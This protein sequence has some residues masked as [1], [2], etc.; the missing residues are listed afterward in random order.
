MS[1]PPALSSAIFFHPWPV[2][3]RLQQSNF[4]KLVGRQC[5]CINPRPSAPI[6]LQPSRRLGCGS[7][8]FLLQ[9]ARSPLPALTCHLVRLLPHSGFLPHPKRFESFLD[10]SRIAEQGLIRSVFAGTIVPRTCTVVYKVGGLHH[11]GIIHPRRRRCHGMNTPRPVFRPGFLS[12]LLSAF[13]RGP[14][15]FRG[16][17]FSDSRLPAPGSK[18]AQSHHQSST[19]FSYPRLADPGRHSAARMLASI[20]G[21]EAV[22]QCCTTGSCRWSCCSTFP[23]RA[24]SVGCVFI[25]QTNA[26]AA[27]PSMGSSP[28]SALQFCPL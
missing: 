27:G 23:S 9:A 10:P 11:H 16:L 24:L 5:R 18:L 19:A 22:A 21:S 2:L 26:H 8:Y 14:L 3:L 4:R 13:I 28:T 12:S 7:S 15:S 1:A 25:E 6:F 20:R 17:S